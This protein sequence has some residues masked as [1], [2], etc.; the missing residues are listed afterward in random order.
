MAAVDEAKLNSFLHKVVT[1]D[2]ALALICSGPTAVPLEQNT[3]RLL[4]N[5]ST[6]QRGAVSA[7]YFLAMGYYVIFF[8]RTNT[9]L[10]FIRQVTSEDISSFAGTH[11]SAHQSG[12][13]QQHATLHPDHRMLLFSFFSFHQYQAG[14]EI[15]CTHAHRL[16]RS[17]LLIFLAAAV[18]DFTPSDVPLHKINS[19]VADLSENLTIT[20]KPTPKVVQ[21]ITSSWAP[22]SMIVSFKLETDKSILKQK[23]IGALE[24]YRCSAIIANHLPSIRSKMMLIWKKTTF[25]TLHCHQKGAEVNGN[26]DCFVFR[27]IDVENGDI[28]EPMVNLLVQLHSAFL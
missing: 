16:M 27:E 1:D 10:P 11:F 22:T 14:L 9:K 15:I 5:I 4:D 17:K 8:H 26:D 13:N 21:Q 6:G 20:L 7:E 12:P 25:P 28:E 24:K 18:S 2:A 3:I 19:S 23:A